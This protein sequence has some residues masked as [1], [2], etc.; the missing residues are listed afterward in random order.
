ML[1]QHQAGMINL[2]DRDLLAL[3]GSLLDRAEEAEARLDMYR[4]DFKTIIEMEH[5]P[6]GNPD[7]IKWELT[8]NIVKKALAGWS[9]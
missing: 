4:E 9:R 1:E 2:Q 7:S 5:E 6:F 3:A 8:L